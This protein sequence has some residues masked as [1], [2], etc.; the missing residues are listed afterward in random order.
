MRC[1]RRSAPSWA[2]L[3]TAV[4]RRLEAESISAGLV[5]EL[6]ETRG[7]LQAESDEHDLLCAAIGVVFDDL[8]VARLEGTSSIMAS[9][10]DITAWVHQL[11]EDAF[12]IRITQAFTVAH[13]HYAESIDLE[14]MSLGFTPGY[15]ASEL[16]EIEMAVT[17]IAW[18]LANR[19][20]DIVLPRR[21]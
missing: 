17:P 15:E 4:A 8:G 3:G 13:S 1:V 14:T 9:A 21:G 18:N 10:V 16:D 5:M 19:I 20:K 6:T 11:E 7:I 12:H 2:D